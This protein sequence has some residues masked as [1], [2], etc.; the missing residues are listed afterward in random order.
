VARALQGVRFVKE[1]T[2]RATEQLFTA[3]AGLGAVI[4]LAT[5][6]EVEVAPA[7]A[8]DSPPSIG[9]VPSRTLPQSSPAAQ[10]DDAVAVVRV[11]AP[12]ALVAPTSSYTPVLGALE[13]VWP[14]D[15]GVMMVPLSSGPTELALDLD[16]QPMGAELRLN[17]DQGRFDEV[18]VSFRYQTSLS[19]GFEGPHWD[20]LDFAHHTSEWM[21]LP[22]TSAGLYV[23]PVL[24]TAQR[25]RFPEVTEA[26]IHTAVREYLSDWED[27]EVPQEALCSD[28]HDSPCS[29]EV[30]RV[31]LRV[32]AFRQGGLLQ[33]SQVV[34][35]VP[36][37]C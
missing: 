35:W 23:V 25:Q 18:Q 2:M 27:P 16:Q 32:R 36:M 20:L 14:Y 9:V 19:L 30:S 13:V 5:V 21:D 15:A 8:A 3:F 26:Q 37:G 22:R 28:P 12:E 33:E 31:T 11:S 10:S 24:S 7:A 17:V 6:A 34:L 1:G 29:V 4:F